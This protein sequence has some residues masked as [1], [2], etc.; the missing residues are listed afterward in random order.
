L[1]K[2]LERYD[3]QFL[4][5]KSGYIL[6]HLKNELRLSDRFFEICEQNASK[7]VRY[8]YGGIKHKQN[9]FDKRWQLFVPKNLLKILSQGGEVH[10]GV[11]QTNAFQTSAGNFPYFNFLDKK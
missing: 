6:N 4:Y 10:G 8:F 1:N 7:S 3:K 5:Q 9:I 2:Y 11:Q